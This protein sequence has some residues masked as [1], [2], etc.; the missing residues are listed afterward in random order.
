MEK[1]GGGGGERVSIYEVYRY[2]INRQGPNVPDPGPLSAAPSAPSPA[3]TASKPAPTAPSS[4][5][6]L[7]RQSL[8]LFGNLLLGRLRERNMKRGEGVIFRNKTYRTVNNQLK[9]C[10]WLFTLRVPLLP[11]LFR[12]V[13]QLVNQ[14]INQPSISQPAIQSSNQ[15]TN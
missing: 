11:V 7:L 14:P 13:S 15:S 8:Q 4:T 1:K 12:R 9:L 5:S 2:R 6:P 3:T 10:L